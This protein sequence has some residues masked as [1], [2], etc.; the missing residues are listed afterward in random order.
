M[1]TAFAQP[2]DSYYA[3]VPTI[4]GNKDRSKLRKISIALFRW[5]KDQIVE[6]DPLR[7]LP[8][9]MRLCVIASAD[10]EKDWDSN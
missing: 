4:E 1:N 7:C 6:S 9:W 3:Q 5:Q 10:P 8:I 2:F